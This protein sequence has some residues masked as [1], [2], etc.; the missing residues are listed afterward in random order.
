MITIKGEPPFLYYRGIVFTV[1]WYVDPAGRMKAKEYYDTL[2][3]EDRK[4]LNDVVEYLADAPIGTRL[5]RTLYNLEDAE[6][7]IYAFKPRDHRF[8]NFMMLGA[9]IIIVNAY[10]KHSQQMTKKDK[11]VLKA[12]IEAKTSYLLRSNAGTYYDWFS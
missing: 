7:Q 3:A 12:A 6:S 4:R 2:P 8:F 11:Q 1:E 5:P 9:K 10:R